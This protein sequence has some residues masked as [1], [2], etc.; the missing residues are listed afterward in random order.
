MDLPLLCSIPLPGRLVHFLRSDEFWE[1][2]VTGD[3]GC[4]N[5][6]LTRKKPTSTKTCKMQL[7]FFDE[8]NIQFLE[9]YELAYMCYNRSKHVWITLLP[10]PCRRLKLANNGYWWV[11]T[12]GKNMS[13]EVENVE[14]SRNSFFKQRPPQWPKPWLFAVCRGLYYLVIWGF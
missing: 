8:W 5:P 2:F 11:E 1:N 9:T 10:Y 6:N 3:L 12:W 13:M 4:K 14:E 7:L